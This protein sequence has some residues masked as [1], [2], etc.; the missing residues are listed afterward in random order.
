M[1]SV[2]GVGNPGA[3]DAGGPSVE[4]DA[5]VPGE[6]E[7]QLEV[8]VLSQGTGTPVANANV[9]CRYGEQGP[10]AD[11]RHFRLF[12]AASIGGSTITEAT[13]PIEI[14]V[15]PEGLQPATLKVHRLTGNILNGE[16]ELLVEVPFTVPDQT[17]GEVRVP[18]SLEV[19][20]DDSIVLEVSMADGLQERNL[21]FGYNLQA[22]T[23]ATYYA[24]DTCGQALPI[25]LATLD[26]PFVPGQTFAPN[27]WLVSLTTERLQ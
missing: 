9:N 23:G 4:A 20:Q 15:S 26:N 17:L 2:D 11:T 19:A 18:L 6:E 3:A 13:L 7:P 10:H 24:S 21:R 5:T 1:D 12:P 25:D 8:V 27:S 14:A 16:F 22:Q